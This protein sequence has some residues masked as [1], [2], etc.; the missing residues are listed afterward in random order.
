MNMTN[1]VML[2]FI[3]IV[4]LKCLYWTE[5]I[6]KGIDKDGE[7]ES[8]INKVREKNNKATLRNEYALRMDTEDNLL[9]STCKKSQMRATLDKLS[10]NICTMLIIESCWAF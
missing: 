4:S 8:E 3:E 2:Y 10:S 6:Q 1:I 5:V 7:K 9:N